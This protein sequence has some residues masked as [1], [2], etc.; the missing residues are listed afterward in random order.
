MLNIKEIIEANIDIR[1]EFF[2]I[3]VEFLLKSGNKVFINGIKVELLFDST[4][5]IFTNIFLISKFV[6]E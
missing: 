3:K 1:A 4:P 6:F 2:S 5:Q